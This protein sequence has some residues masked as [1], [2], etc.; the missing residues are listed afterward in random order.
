M[1][2]ILS[3]KGFDSEAGG[4][5]SPILPDGTMLSL[6]IP[7]YDKICFVNIGYGQGKSYFRLSWNRNLPGFGFFKFDP[8]LVL[9]KD[10]CNKSKWKLPNFFRNT[11][12]SYHEKKAWRKGYFQSVARGQEFVVEENKR[13]TNW[14]KSLIEKCIHPDIV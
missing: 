1:K 10:G 5:P 3:R 9:T 13:V 6:P 8:C 12:I 2:I 14:A 11:N 7:S 4:Y